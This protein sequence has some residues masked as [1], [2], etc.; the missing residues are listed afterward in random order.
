MLNAPPGIGKTMASLYP[1]L[2]YIISQ[3]KRLFI[4]TSKTTQQE[5]YLESFKNLLKEGSKFKSIRI[6]SKQ[7]YV[8]PILMTVMK[9]I[10][11]YLKNILTSKI[12]H[13]PSNY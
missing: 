2:K 10:V 13:Y 6:T 3:N 9:M 5:I 12:I 8:K 7:K 11:H 1:S 4:T